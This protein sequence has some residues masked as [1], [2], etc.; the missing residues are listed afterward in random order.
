MHLRWGLVA[1]QNCRQMLVVYIFARVTHFGEGEL[2]SIVA[3]INII[4]FEE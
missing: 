3:H 1:P 2:Y 4:G